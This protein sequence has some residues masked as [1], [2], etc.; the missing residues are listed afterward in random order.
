MAHYTLLLQDYCSNDNSYYTYIYCVHNNYRHVDYDDGVPVAL[1][2]YT[3]QV[4]NKMR[5]TTTKNSAT[6]HT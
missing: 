2:C 6:T 5:V 1:Y 3:V 4:L